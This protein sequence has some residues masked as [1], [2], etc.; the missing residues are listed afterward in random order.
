MQ[1]RVSPGAALFSVS[2]TSFLLP[3]MLSGVAVALPTMGKEF[4]ATAVQLGL[5]ETAYV[6]STSIFLLAMGRLGD[7]HGRRRVFQAGIAVFTVVGALLSRA[8]SMETVIAFRFLQGIG[9]AMVGA[10][11]FAIVVATY[12]PQERGKALGFSVAAVYAG[13]SCGPFLGG[14]LV[15]AF[16]WRSLFYVSVPAGIVTFLLVSWRLRGEWAEAKGEPFDWQGSLVY[17]LSIV[18]LVT[19]AANLDKAAWSWA[20]IAVGSASLAAFLVLEARTEYPVLDVDLLRRNRVFTLSNVAALLNYAATF[21]VTFFLSFYLQRIKGMSPHHAG[22]VLMIQ[23]VAQT[24]FSPLFGRLSDRV[25]A[26]RVATA[27]MAVCAL[28]LGVAAT[29]SAST[30]LWVLFLV[31]VCLGM[32][33]ALFTSPNTSVIMGSVPPKYLG[34]ASGLASS[35][36]TL[37]MLVSMLVI[38]VILS[39]LMGGRPVS[40]ETQDAFL[41]SMT[42]GL[43]SFCLLCGL[44]IVCSLARLRAGS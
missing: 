43:V 16:G 20:V 33:F 35:M 23:P 8:W 32:G 44:G 40:P 11:G 29:L 30:P 27:G 22:L 10:T 26:E 13:L 21:G 1:Q 6:L 42:T 4:G 28:G 17:G 41:L 15:S 39:V 19:G 25:P 14:A 24:V 12:P 2:L 5:V 18:L 38:N 31:L 9:G 34:V 37:G 3:F 36:R 7:I